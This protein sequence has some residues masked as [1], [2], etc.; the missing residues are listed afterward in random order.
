MKVN[1]EKS[2]NKTQDMD[3]KQICWSGC[4]HLMYNV[5]RQLSTRIDHSTIISV[6]SAV[7]S[8]L[9]SLLLALFML[10]R[11]PVGLVAILKKGG[12]IQLV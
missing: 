9:L 4:M 7:V 6:Y 11:L 2:E 1:Y 12:R 10:P 5:G 3:T 8:K